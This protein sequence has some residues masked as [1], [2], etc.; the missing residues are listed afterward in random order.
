MPGT[1]PG[2]LISRYILGRLGAVHHS[3]LAAGAAAVLRGNDRGRMTAAA[4]RLYPHQ[5]SWDAAFIAIGLAHLCVP[6]AITELTS[7]LAGQWSTG[8]IPHIV[9]GDASGYF[10]GP[11]RW[12]SQESP[13]A[14]RGVATSGICQ[15]PVHSLAL[16]HLVA[17]ARRNGQADRRTAED[18][19]AASFDS[20]LAWHRW[21]ATARDP[22][23]AGLLEINHGW[24]SGMDNSPRWDAPYARVHP[25][26]MEPFE[27]RDTAHVRDPSERPS[28]LDY[29]RYVW[30]V[31]Q[32][33]GVRYADDAARGCDFRV[34]D[35][36]MS[37]VFAVS[38]EVLA[39]L[40]DDLGRDA[41]GTELRQLADRFR[42]GVS[43][44]V[45]DGSGL[46]RDRDVRTGEWLAGE[47]VG[48]FAPLL[49]GADDA[50]VERQRALL[51]GPRWCGYPRLRHALPPTT[52]PLAPEFHRRAY[53]RGP[54]WPVL[55]WL[56]CWAASRRGDD[57]LAGRF[58]EEALHQLD[59]GSFAEYYEPFTGEPLGSRAQSWTA[60]VTLAWLAER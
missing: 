16:A 49:C 1:F 55:T 29:R 47:T 45:D 54:Q 9:F 37:A 3:E 14:P 8:M 38:S 28:D 50:L 35:V 41:A 42:A 7:L 48:G 46:A 60:A 36:F 13:Y 22:G 23:R 34:A 44:T 2:S 10:P 56:F 11:Q 6:R 27:R 21:L 20:W 5:W 52:S 24:E 25:G 51:I 40:A 57:E 12:R 43:G 31:D 18:F 15:P 19:L 30:L 33:A 39:E 53:W 32:L 17:V 59:D 26:A 58:R 4:P